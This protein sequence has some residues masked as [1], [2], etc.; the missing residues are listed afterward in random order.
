[1][2]GEII[3]AARFARLLS[4][5][6]TWPCWLGDITVITATWAG[7]PAGGHAWVVGYW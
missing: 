3:G 7:P 2:D 6:N 1:M 4:A 5:A